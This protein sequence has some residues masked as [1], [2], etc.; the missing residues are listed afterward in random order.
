MLQNAPAQSSLQ[1][2][3]SQPTG[4]YNE[5]LREEYDWLMNSDFGCYSS[6]FTPPCDSPCELNLN[7]KDS[8]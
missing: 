8:L 7:R 6:D 3:E 5:R 2:D 1:R 4:T